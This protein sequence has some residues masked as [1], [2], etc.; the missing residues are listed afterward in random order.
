MEK[1]M[2]KN[3]LKFSILLFLFLDCG[4]ADNQ[5]PFPC[6]G[7]SYFCCSE[8]ICISIGDLV[9]EDKILAVLEFEK[10]IGTSGVLWMEGENKLGSGKIVLT[11]LPEAEHEIK[12]VDG[13]GNTLDKINVQVTREKGF[14]YYSGGGTIPIF[15]VPDKIRFAF[16]ENSGEYK[17]EDFSIQ[18][19]FSQDLNK[20]NLPEGVEFISFHFE[21]ENGDRY[22]PTNEFMCKFEPDI[23]RDWIDNFNRINQVEI[24]ERGYLTDPSKNEF[25]LRTRHKTNLATLFT[26]NRYYENEN[27]KY[28]V[29]D[30]WDEGLKPLTLLS[31]E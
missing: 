15:F 12:V 19:I 18:D 13:G 2:R 26:A 4:C 10:E 25:L 1:L 30:A 7:D 5:N 23:S 11:L 3:H 22:I 27:T 21:H 9:K 20:F 14:Y 16:T 17:W 24:I 6:S 29:P 28:S 31:L 8:H